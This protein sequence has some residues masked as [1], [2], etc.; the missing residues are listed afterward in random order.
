[1]AAPMR[2]LQGGLR[3]SYFCRSRIL[4]RF[5]QQSTVG[6]YLK[7]NGLSTESIVT[8]MSDRT[9]W[10]TFYKRKQEPNFNWFLDFEDAH[11][12]LEKYFPK[13]SNWPKNRRF[14][15]L[16]IGCGTSYFSMDFLNRVELD[17][18]LWCVDFSQVAVSQL[19]SCDISDK[20]V[21]R[22]NL[23]RDV[24]FVVADTC[25]LPFKGDVIDI[26]LDKGTLD[27]VLRAGDSN[28]KATSCIYETLRVLTTPGI[29]LHFSDEHPDIRLHFLQQVANQ[30]MST[31]ENIS[32]SV[33]YQ[34]VTD[35]CDPIEYFMYTV[36]K[37][38]R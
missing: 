3:Q 33:G 26:A 4:N 20:V 29:F 38:I 30:Y 17:S 1:M 16:D 6:C 19:A 5:L 12:Q 35:T 34:S 7:Y 25:A 18:T 8:N 2:I 22:K 36:S 24:N 32:L 31:H 9:T 23:S 10:N 37:S 21:K 11:E 28:T 14:H 15:I 13:P 27:A